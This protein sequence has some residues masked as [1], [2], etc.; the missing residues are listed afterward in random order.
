MRSSALKVHLKIHNKNPFNLH[1]EV[2]VNL[3]EEN[4]LNIH[5]SQAL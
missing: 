5:K 1:K 3:I 4:Q 2:G